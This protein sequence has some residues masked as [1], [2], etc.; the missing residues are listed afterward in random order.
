MLVARRVVEPLWAA[1]GTL[2]FA[3]ASYCIG[4]AASTYATPQALGT[5][6]VIALAAGSGGYALASTLL[7][8][9]APRLDRPLPEL[10]DSPAGG[11]A[12]IILC[13]HE[14]ER[15]DP[16][17]TAEAL[18]LLEDEEEVD[19]SIAMTPVLYAAAKARY[20]AAGG[21]SPARKQLLSLAEKVAVALPEGAAPHGVSVANCS[22][23]DRLAD[24]VEAALARGATNVMV[25]TL[26]V[27]DSL[28]ASSAKQEVDAWRLDERGITVTYLPSLWGSERIATLVT[29]RIENATTEPATT[30][31][32]LVIHGQNAYRAQRN[33]EFDVNESAFASRIRLLCRELGIPETNVRTAW[34]G[35]NEPDV[36]GTV[37]HLAA[38]GCSRILVVPAAYPLETISTL[39]DFSAAARSARVDQ[40]VAV[41]SLPAWRDD[42]QVVAELAAR[43]TEALSGN[44]KA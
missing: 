17:H 4:L 37:R 5:T 1:A 6:I 9:L 40:S 3:V 36:T 19:L 18:H 24:A 8:R 34:A 25:A 16:H 30:G 35:W 38:L 12:V 14:P 22:G 21:T 20:R 26:G 15:Y 13:C 7:Y 32:V 27:G 42:D 44:G 43:V 41:T 29:K 10:P 11:T 39:L 33:P 31:V 23:P 2:S 28:P